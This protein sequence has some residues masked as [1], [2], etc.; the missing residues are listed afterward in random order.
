MNIAKRTIL[1][2]FLLQAT[3]LVMVRTTLIIHRTGLADSCRAHQL[4]H[5]V[6]LG[7]PQCYN[8]ICNEGG[9]SDPRNPNPCAGE[10]GVAYCCTRGCVVRTREIA[11]ES[12]EDFP[13]FE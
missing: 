3:L 4:Q 12:T 2:I 9:G 1:S 5:P 10:S 11:I 8:D 13:F 6:C 7:T